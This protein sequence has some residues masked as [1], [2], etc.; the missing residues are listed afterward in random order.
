MNTIQNHIQVYTIWVNG[1]SIKDENQHFPIDSNIDNGLGWHSDFK[2]ASKDFLKCKAKKKDKD[3]GSDLENYFKDYH[4][5]LYSI[6]INIVEFEK[7]YGIEFDLNDNNVQ[8]YIPYY[9][10]YDFNVVAER[11]ANF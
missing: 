10:D 3:Y 7:N 8:E 11:L 5:A 4:I 1:R 2:K 9:V 6:D